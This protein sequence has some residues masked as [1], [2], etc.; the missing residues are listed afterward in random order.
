MA[1]IV[2]SLC[3]RSGIAVERWAEA[4]YECWCVDIEHDTGLGPVR[5][6]VR[7]VG[8]DVRG[9]RVP[10]GRE[11]AFCMAFPPCTHLAISGARWFRGK[12]LRSLATAIELVACCAEIADECRAPWMIENP[13]ST[14]STYW[15]RPCYKFD[16]CDYAGY[17][18]D[19]LENAYTKRT[20]L[21][22]GNGFIL[23]VKK[24]VEPVYGSMMHLL[25]PSSDRAT[26]RSVT[27]RGFSNAVFEANY[28][29]VR[30]RCPA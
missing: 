1:P 16:P 21:W 12:G 8:G 26:L 4:G 14:L 7:M 6:N 23:P 25:P 18:T 5:D 30:E 29:M 27:P 17:L 11:I 24:W 10:Q 19:P 13:M 20:C 9:F 15:R 2:L 22:T 3:D 28:P